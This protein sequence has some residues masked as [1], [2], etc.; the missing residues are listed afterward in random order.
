VI[1]IEISTAA[2][3]AN[4]G[5]RSRAAIAPATINAEESNTISWPIPNRDGSTKLP[6]A[7]PIA[8]A[9]PPPLDDVV[10]HGNQVLTES[11]AAQSATNHPG[12]NTLRRKR[13]IPRP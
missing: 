11:R 5:D 6:T 10:N 4:R 12:R 1:N 3:A 8:L 7:P 9:C 2:D 13:A